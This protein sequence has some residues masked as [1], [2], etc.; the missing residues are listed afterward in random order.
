M[1]ESTNNELDKRITLALE[2]APTPPIA[3]DFALQVMQHLPAPSRYV[4]ATHFVATY[5]GR[6]VAVGTLVILTALMFW[7]APHA[8]SMGHGTLTFIEL[9]LCAEFVA[10]ILYLSPLPRL[11]R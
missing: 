9:L 7:L 10:V 8:F 2:T 11:H 3:D 4:T 6:R 5:V 1:N